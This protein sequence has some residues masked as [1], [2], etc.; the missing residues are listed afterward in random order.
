MHFK[1]IHI[2][3]DFELG[4]A[5]IFVSD[6]DKKMK[7]EIRKRA[8]DD[9]YPP[10]EKGDGIAVA[11]CEK[12]LSERLM[13]AASSTGKLSINKLDVRAAYDEM[14]SLILRTLRLVRWRT[15]SL[16]QPNPIRFAKYFGWSVD[17]QKW[18]PVSD[19][20]KLSIEL[21]VIPE[22]T[23]ASEEFIRYEARGLLDEPI[24]HELLREADSNRKTNLRS[25]LVLAIAAAEVGFKQFVSLTFPDT[26]WILDLPAPPLV[27]L[28]AHF[29]WPKLSVV[30]DGI[31]VSIPEKT[32]GL[33]K[34]AVN[35][36]NQIVHAG[37]VDLK[38]Q[39]LKELIKGV[40]DFLYLLD[41]CR[42][43]KW[44]FQHLDSEFRKELRSLKQNAQ[45]SRSHVR[46]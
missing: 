37:N 20:I 6:D 26:S 42:G 38:E 46:R 22:W 27:D 5:Q 24:A 16:G 11:N 9:T 39:T 14:Q 44:A 32:M 23:S 10:F 34:K 33:F 1:L 30:I 3:R 21:Q 15:N 8:S 29:P 18:I 35:L 4:D 13:N 2:T 12:Q 36:R 41:G 28:I 43:Q 25:S 19:N 40:R 7:V 31:T 45:A 17:G